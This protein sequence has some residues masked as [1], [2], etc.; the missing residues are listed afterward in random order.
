MGFY[1]IVVQDCVST[2]DTKE[3]NDW[4][5]KILEKVCLVAPSKKIVAEWKR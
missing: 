5:L 4:A 3:M 1:T 2:R